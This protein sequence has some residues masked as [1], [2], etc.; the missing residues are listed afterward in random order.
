MDDGGGDSRIGRIW[1]DLEP[2]TL[3]SGDLEWKGKWRRSGG[4]Q[5]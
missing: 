4:K 1:E 3:K 5:T 2:M